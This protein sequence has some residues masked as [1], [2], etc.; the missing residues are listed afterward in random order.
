M[1]LESVARPD[2]AQYCSLFPENR[3]VCDHPC[4]FVWDEQTKKCWQAG[5]AP[6]IGSSDAP[7]SAPIVGGT[8]EFKY[9]YMPDLLK[10]EG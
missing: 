5:T 9:Q 4:G 7:M 6:I 3:N 1:S 8:G 10:M 2:A